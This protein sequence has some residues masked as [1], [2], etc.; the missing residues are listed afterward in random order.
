MSNILRRPLRSRFASWKIDLTRQGVSQDP[1]GMA[2]QY[3]QKPLVNQNER[4]PS[5]NSTAPKSQ[6]NHAPHLHFVAEFLIPHIPYW[7]TDNDPKNCLWS[8]L[9]KQSMNHPTDTI[10]RPKPR[11]KD[12]KILYKGPEL[13]GP[14]KYTLQFSGPSEVQRSHRCEPAVAG[15]A[16]APGA[17]AT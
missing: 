1:T 8:P 15:A 5:N 11:T 3:Q 2:Q 4:V 9:V 6:N 13:F 7:Q 16:G 14:Q 12:F 17:G 10:K